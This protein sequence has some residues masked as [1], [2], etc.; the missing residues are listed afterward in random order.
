MASFISS[1]QL[2]NEA[3]NRKLFEEQEW[4]IRI[5]T[6]VL[7]PNGKPALMLRQHGDCTVDDPRVYVGYYDNIPRFVPA[8][9]VPISK[10]KFDALV[11]NGRIF[12]GIAV[13]IHDTEFRVVVD[14]VCRNPPSHTSSNEST[15]E[16]YLEKLKVQQSSCHIGPELLKLGYNF[17]VLPPKGGFKRTREGRRAVCMRTEKQQMALERQAMELEQTKSQMHSHQRKDRLMSACLPKSKEAK[18]D[19]AVE[20]TLRIMM[21]C[22]L[23]PEC[24]LLQY[25]CCDDEG[26]VLGV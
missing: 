13:C 22:G 21:P 23:T 24:T 15:A 17:Y 6:A 25:D 9:Y 26:M 1:S 12:N 8:A 7:G 3:A 2:P 14:V 11:H 4:Q 10:L 5:Y 18:E 16:G 20:P 19:D